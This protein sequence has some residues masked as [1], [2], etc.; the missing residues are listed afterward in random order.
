MW[1]D[2]VHGMIMDHGT[3]TVPG[4]PELNQLF[5]LAVVQVTEAWIGRKGSVP[6]GCA[7]EEDKEDDAERET[8]AQVAV[9]VAPA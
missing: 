3:E 7:S 5:H 9:E 2:Q 1:T 8:I 4:L 6:R